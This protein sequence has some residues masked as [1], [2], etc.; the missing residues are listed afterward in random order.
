MKTL[1]FLLLGAS[2]MG[3]PLWVPKGAVPAGLI[4]QGP[5]PNTGSMRPM[6][7]G[8]EMYWVESYIGQPVSVGDLV[9]I[10]QPYGIPLLHTVVAQN[11]THVI[12]SGV[13]NKRSDG[14]L[15]KKG[16]LYIVR[17]IE[18]PE[19]SHLSQVR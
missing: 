15:P 5:V 17:Y 8:G 7:K 16:I 9:G 14:W 10:L 3:S 11:K 1:L 2:L 13:A 12:T 18:R 4:R 19:P 6:L